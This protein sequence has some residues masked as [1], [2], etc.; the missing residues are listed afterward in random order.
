MVLVHCPKLRIESI[1][2]VKWNVNILTGVDP[3]EP[4]CRQAGRTR[5]PEFA[6][7]DVQPA[8]GPH[9]RNY[10]RKLAYCPSLIRYKNY[11]EELSNSLKEGFSNAAVDDDNRSMQ[12]QLRL[13]SKEGASPA[14]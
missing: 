5:V 4:A 8:P 13:A 14:H 11:N 9:S 3:T 2:P 1:S 10:I 7:P 12:I 6:V